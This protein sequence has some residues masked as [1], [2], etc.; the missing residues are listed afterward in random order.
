MATAGGR[1][2]LVDLPDPPLAPNGEPQG[3]QDSGSG[4]GLTSAQYS[5][6]VLLFLFVVAIVI[7]W[8]CYP[9]CKKVEEEQET[10]SH[11]DGGGEDRRRARRQRQQQQAAAAVPEPEVVVDT[12]KSGQHAAEP[13]L[14]CTY[15]AAEGWEERTC[16]VCLAELQ[17]GEAVRMLMP[18]AHYF[19][20][21]CADRWMRTSATCPICRAP[22]AGAGRRRRRT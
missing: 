11:E 14:E 18:C 5:G 12:D 8:L 20:A 15:R 17:D 22:T 21:A 7:A 16:S 9:I 19:H 2:R 10:T 3:Q 4:G 6:V 13:A 1:R